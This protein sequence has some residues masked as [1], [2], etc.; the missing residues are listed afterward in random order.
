MTEATVMVVEDQVLVARDIKSRLI[1]MGYDVIATATK[2][3][4]AI[5]KALSLHPQLILM[6]VNLRDDMDGIEAAVLFRQEYDV[7]VIFCTAFSDAEILNRAKISDLY[8]YVLKPFENRELEI[9]I[10]IALYKHKAEL[11]LKETKR[12][13]NATLANVSDGIIAVDLDGKIFLTN[14]VAE[15]LTGWTQEEAIGRS[16]PEVL[17][18]KS[19]QSQNYV[20]RCGEVHDEIT[21]RRLKVTQLDG[22]ET[23]IELGVNRIQESDDETS[24]YVITFRD[25]SQ[26]L[27]YEGQIRHNALYDPLT[28]LPNRTLLVD[29]LV[30]SINATKRRRDRLFSVL[31]IDLD[32]F[33]VVNE[34][35]G[36]QVGDKLIS[37]TGERIAEMIRPS[38]T[39]SRFSGDIFC[40]LLDPVASAADVIQ[41]CNRIQSAIAK[42]LVLDDKSVNVTATAGIVLDE[43][44]YDTASDLVRDADTAMHRAKSE[45]K[46]SYV[47]FDDEM[48]ENILRFM[49]WKDGMQQA[50][51]QNSFEVFYQPIVSTQTEELVNRETPRLCWGGTQSLTITG[52]S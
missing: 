21:H 6:D 10:E 46:G 9:N 42:P 7:P 14:P 39:L 44:Q 24:G 13:L 1:Q 12:Q 17:S 3:A 19:D 27:G 47:I 31:L 5:D 50:V 34:G 30:H 4:E 28:N 16:L 22:S 2:G 32:E 25:I 37:V 38:D 23:P 33:R 40:I 11:D 45:S 15:S 26:Q 20:L 35:L 49:E 52:V 8:G 43:G 18:L 51:H 41:V 36:H 48:H 29:R